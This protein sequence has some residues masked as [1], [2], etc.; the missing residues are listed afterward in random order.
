MKQHKL[1]L[2]SKI[3]LELLTAMVSAGAALELSLMAKSFKCAD[4]FLTN[5]NIKQS[6]T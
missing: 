6:L 3:A 5:A 4:E 2:R 1:D